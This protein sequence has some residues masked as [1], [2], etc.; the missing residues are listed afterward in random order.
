MSKEQWYNALIGKTYYEAFQIIWNP[1]RN[2]NI[3]QRKALIEYHKKIN[4][5]IKIE[6]S[7]KAIEEACD[8]KFWDI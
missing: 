8:P 2:L 3:Q 7:K 6:Q 5:K 1:K 4:D